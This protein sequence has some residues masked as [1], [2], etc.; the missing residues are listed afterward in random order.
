MELEHHF[1]LLFYF[2]I[3]LSGQV[4]DFFF[5][6]SLYF[7]LL[8]WKQWL[9][10]TLISGAQCPTVISKYLPFML[11]IGSLYNQIV[12]I[13]QENRRCLILSTDQDR[14]KCSF[15]RISYTKEKH[16]NVS[17]SHEAWHICSKSIQRH[18][19]GVFCAVLFFDGRLN[20]NLWLSTH[21]KSI[22][23]MFVNH[24]VRLKSDFTLFPLDVYY[25][26]YI[27]VKLRVL[28]RWML[29]INHSSRI[30]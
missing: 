5:N 23:G 26:P 21:M 3:S 11:H 10:A 14:C 19:Y 2:I 7:S 15:L 28:L 25:N 6:F 13:A 17:W 1:C 18:L 20:S 9:V 4:K 8:P 12:T 29:W 24:I 30:S 27:Y 22:S 16:K